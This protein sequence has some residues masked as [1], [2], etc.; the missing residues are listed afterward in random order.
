MDEDLKQT[1]S[2]RETKRKGSSSN[3][4]RKVFEPGTTLT[5]EVVAETMRNE[6]ISADQAHVLVEQLYQEMLNLDPT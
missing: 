6:S 5:P 1:L 3:L 2:Y 4:L